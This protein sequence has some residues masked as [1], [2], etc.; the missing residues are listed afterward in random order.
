MSQPVAYLVRMDQAYVVPQL[1]AHLEAGATS[2]AG[3]RSVLV[4]VLQVGVQ[5]A[6]CGVAAITHGALEAWLPCQTRTGSEGSE[7]WWISV[8]CCTHVASKLVA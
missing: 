6:P 8:K 5:A 3:M 1:V 2:G 7:R 4:V